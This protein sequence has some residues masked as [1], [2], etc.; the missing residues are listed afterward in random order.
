MI[1]VNF[2]NI[3]KGEKSSTKITDR[4]MNEENAFETA[5]IK[6]KKSIKEKDRIKTVANEGSEKLN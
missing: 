1:F 3:K 5:S 4:K 6:E 2:Q